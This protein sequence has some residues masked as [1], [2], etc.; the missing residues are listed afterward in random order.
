[1]ALLNGEPKEWTQIAFK[2]WPERTFKNRTVY[3]VY[4]S[5]FEF[6][7]IKQTYGFAREKKKFFRM[8]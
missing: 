5:I 8:T 2:L 7:V 4:L 3:E 6:E 1:M